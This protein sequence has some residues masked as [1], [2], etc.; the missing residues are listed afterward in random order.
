MAADRTRPDHSR[1]SAV[2]VGISAYRDPGYQDPGPGRLVSAA[3]S[4]ALMRR[5]LT[6][7]AMCDWPAE[8]IETIADPASAGELAVRLRDIARRT[9]GTLLLYY[10]GHGELTANGELVLTVT[11]TLPDAPK[12]TGLRFDLVRDAFNAS[13]ARVKVAILDCCGAGRAIPTTLG[14]PTFA[15]GAR[16]AG[17]HILTAA[18]GNSDSHHPPAADDPL[19]P[20]SFTG[21][22][23]DVL[24]RGVPGK[25]AWLTLADIFPELALR[26]REQGLPGPGQ[27]VSDTANEAPFARNAANTGTPAVPAPATAPPEDGQLRLLDRQAE[28]NATPRVRETAAKFG[29]DLTTVKGTGVGG[30]IRTGDVMA[31]IRTRRGPDGRLPGQKPPSK[32]WNKAFGVLTWLGLIA[33]YGAVFGDFWAFNAL[34]EDPGTSTLF[35]L[36]GIIAFGE[37]LG[38][39]MVCGSSLRTVAKEARG[40]FGVASSVAAV[41]G[42]LAGGVTTCF[43]FAGFFRILSRF[44]MAPEAAAW[45]TLA[46]AGVATIMAVRDLTQA[47]EDGQEAHRPQ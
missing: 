4:L 20:T 47:P 1:S 41:C 25:P 30:R 45:V 43:A 31:V 27:A 7:P 26:L 37:V 15:G 3:N 16:V 46:C 13:P 33:V 29:V 38:T 17:T 34:Y 24:R 11:T 44:R 21:A 23:A 42:F 28:P 5:L 32:Y 18:T 8:R 19:A 40:G 14:A 36:T 10:V 6:D 9:T 22:L 35:K 39:A 2:V 12:E